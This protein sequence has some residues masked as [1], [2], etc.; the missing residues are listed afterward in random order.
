M[1]VKIH[2]MNKSIFVFFCQFCNGS[3]FCD[4]L[5]ASLDDEK[6]DIVCCLMTALVFRES[7]FPAIQPKTDLFR[8]VAR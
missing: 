3:N 8:E 5:F 2:V 7:L 4:F 6:R 1:H